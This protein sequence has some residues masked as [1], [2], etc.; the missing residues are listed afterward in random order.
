M[1]YIQHFL[2]YIIACK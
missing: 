2:Q 1:K